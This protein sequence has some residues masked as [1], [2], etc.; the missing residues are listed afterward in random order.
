[1]SARLFIALW[2]DV[3]IAR[4]LL[5]QAGVDPGDPHQG[6]VALHNV[7]LTLHFL[8]AVQQASLPAL[9]AALR[10]PFQPFELS[11]SR[12]EHWAHGL[13][14]AVPDRLTPPLRQLHMALGDMLNAF[15][16]R[17]DK[18]PFQPHLTL[19]R[20]HATPLPVMTDLRLRWHVAGYALAE[21]PAT[22]DGAYHLL[23]H[24]T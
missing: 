14:V 3:A 8:G 1:M 13:L 5:A 23:Q 4:A 9:V 19:A 2:P 15:G 12:C 22:P 24:Y 11:F 18:R 6:G 10:V 16:L 21:S 7:H 17:V 20:R